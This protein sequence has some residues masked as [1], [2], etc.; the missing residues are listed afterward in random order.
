MKTYDK[1][2][3]ISDGKTMNG[4]NEPWLTIREALHETMALNKSWS[5]WKSK[6]GLIDG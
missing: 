5:K 3:P 6:G 2:N 1:T 4:N